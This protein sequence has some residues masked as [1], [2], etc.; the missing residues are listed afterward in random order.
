[1]SALRIAAA[2]VLAKRGG[3]HTHAWYSYLDRQ[4]IEALV[5]AQLN[6]TERAVYR[7]MLADA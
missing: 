6:G 5:L 4:D 3:Y 7:K 1:M 2:F